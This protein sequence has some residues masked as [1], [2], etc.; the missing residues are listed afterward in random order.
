MS[1]RGSILAL[2]DGIHA[3][4]V[5]S[6]GDLTPA[7]FD[8]VIAA[9]ASLDVVILG[10]GNAMQRPPRAVRALFEDQRLPLDFMNTSSA[11]STYNILLAEGRRVAAALIAVEHLR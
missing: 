1:H 3:W 6:A 11:V 7:D 9:R 2:P 8:Q 10:T 4:N 5:H